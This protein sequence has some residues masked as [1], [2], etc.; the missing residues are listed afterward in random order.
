MM[1][2]LRIIAR[3][4]SHIYDLLFLAKGCGSKTLEEIEAELDV[5]EYY[6]RPYA[7]ADDDEIIY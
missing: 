2:K 5:T 7:D 3:L 4:W 1:T 6:C